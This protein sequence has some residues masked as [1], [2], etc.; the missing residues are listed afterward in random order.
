MFRNKK[1][2]LFNIGVTA[3][4]LLVYLLVSNHYDKYTDTHAIHHILEKKITKEISGIKSELKE[5]TP[6]NSEKLTT[7]SEEAEYR[8]FIYLKNDSLRFY[9]TNEIV[10][11]DSCLNTKRLCAVKTANRIILIN[12]VVIAPG[13][14]VL[15]LITIRKSYELS[16]QFLQNEFVIDENIPLSVRVDMDPKRNGIRIND[17]AVFSLSSEQQL[18]LRKDVINGLFIIFLVALLS[19]FITIKQLYEELEFMNGRVGLR[20]LGVG[21]D[22]FLVLAILLYFQ[23]PGKLFSSYLFDGALF[24]FPGVFSSL[25]AALFILTGTAVVI[26]SLFMTHFRTGIKTTTAGVIHS[27]VIVVTAVAILFFPYMLIKNLV[28]NSSIPLSL[29]QLD[30]IDFTSVLAIITIFLGGISA[31]LLH[32]KLIGISYS[33]NRQGRFYWFYIALAAGI[34]LYLSY[35]HNRLYL[36]ILL[37]FMISG[38]F[39]Y[40]LKGKYTLTFSIAILVAAAVSYSMILE[41]LNEQKER[42]QIKVRAISLLNNRDKISEYRFYEQTQKMEKDETLDSLVQKYKVNALV[43]DR[44]LSYIQENYFTSFHLKYNLNFTFC[45]SETQLMID[46]ED[47]PVDCYSYFGNIINTMGKKTV[48]DNLYY[49]DDG[50]EIR[51]YIGRLSLDKELNLFLDIYQKSSPLAQGYPELLESKYSEKMLDP[52]YSYAIYFRGE[53]VNSYGDVNYPIYFENGLDISTD[54]YVHFEFPDKSEKVLV[55]S[56]KRDTFTEIF[57][58]ATDFILIFGILLLIFYFI[59]HQKLNLSRLVSFRSRLQLSIFSILL[60]SFII[61]GY[62]VFSHISNQNENKNQNNLEEL[63]HSIRIELEH[64]FAHLDDMSE[65]S[66]GYIYDQLIKFSKVFF[67]DINLF[68]TR[69]QLVVSSRPKVFDRN[70]ISRRINP[71]PY[72]KLKKKDLAIYIHKEKI[73]DY[74]FLSSYFPLRNYENKVIAY[75]NLPYFSKQRRLTQEI[76]AFLTT[77]IN[78]YILLTIASL[79]IVWVI[80]NYITKPMETIKDFLRK[81]KLQGKNAKIEIN[82]KDEIGDLVKEY[83]SM[84][85][86][87]EKSARLLAASERETAWREMARQVAHEI[88]NPLTPMKLS[89]QQFERSFLKNPEE[90]KDTVKRFTWNMIQQIDS[91][92]EI[93][94]A[95]SDF[96]KMPKASMKKLNVVAIINDTKE[97]FEGEE[98]TEVETYFDSG[99]IYI[100]ADYKQMQRVFINLIKNSIQALSSRQNGKVSIEGY[101][102]EEKVVI[103]VKDN[104]PGIPEDKK[105]KIFL[106]N[107]TTKSGGTGLGLAMVKNIVTGF[108]GDIALV[109]S[110]QTG[111]IFRLT[112][113]LINESEL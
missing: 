104:G 97:L 40:Y 95:F 60:F 10:W 68:N 100:E 36:F 85:D 32:L 90:S 77:F 8:N 101:K 11:P 12:P 7:L 41:S 13:E 110:D 6:V 61:I 51:N 54:K 106:P 27:V 15:H 66:E 23:I 74:K 25:G 20:I 113:P 57:A 94:S 80:S 39:M 31:V 107:F 67:S 49:I 5:N 50:D 102:K 76:S 33:L 26:W 44:L 35:T 17:T 18:D 69:G 83:N 86:E 59:N 96:A 62:F 38:I 109:K 84:V 28:L 105:D 92:S 70:I 24:I 45:D 99:E 46:D 108:G 112:F 16:N 98:R 48:S 9:T 72:S 19:L 71:D 73:G 30:E 89:V 82:R 52:Q 93:A 47:N 43:E 65:I 14:K 37:Q 4:L 53:L 111:T 81:T 75:V 88:K 34:I 55:I 78:I 1:K 87:L 91:L 2:V 22:I 58:S 29:N 42:Q 63:S 79:F 64:K 21:F 3:I 56:K 103:L